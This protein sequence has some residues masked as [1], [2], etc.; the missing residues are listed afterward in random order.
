[1]YLLDTN[2]L[3][4]RRKGA[5]ADPGVV[6]FIDRQGDISYIPVQVIGELRSGIEGLRLRNDL[7]Q[8]KLLED[9]LTGVLDGYSDHVID[10]TLP[11]AQVWGAL[12][13]VNDQHIVDRQIAAIAL[14]YDLTIVTR[15]T[16]H[17]AGTGARVVNPFLS[18][19]QPPMSTA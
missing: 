13:G 3:S 10:F 12:T 4:E 15:N 18:D 11:C 5:K 2:V 17:F 16:A 1:V 8:A 19:I 6:S 9:W 7:R 14:V